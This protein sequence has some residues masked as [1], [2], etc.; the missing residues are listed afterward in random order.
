MAEIYL[1]R[2]QLTDLD[3]IMNI[4]EQAKAHL[5]EVGSPQWQDG[6]PNRQILTEDISRQINWVL[7][8]GH[9]IAG[10]ASLQ[11]TP[12]PAYQVIHQGQW[13]QPNAPYATI[14]RIAINDQFRGQG[15]GKLLFSNLLTVGVMQGLQNF[16]FDT[17]QMNKPMQALGQKFNFI[18]RGI[19]LVD[20]QID[21]E[22]IAFELNLGGH[23]QLTHIN[24]D[25]MQGLIQ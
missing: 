3:Q 13:A 12:D 7:M 18:Q 2:A 8:N 14:H 5:K 10:T 24:N 25:F 21:R 15:M 4:I 1:R 20:D 22:R 17:H 6:H 11:L 16:R 23:H 19:V 9:Q